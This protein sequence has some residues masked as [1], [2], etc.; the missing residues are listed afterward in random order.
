M[1]TRRLMVALVASAVGLAVAPGTALAQA[2]HLEQA[3]AETKEAI[4]EGKRDEPAS[5]VEHAVNAIDHAHAAQKANPS[6]HIKSGISHLKKAVKW[7]KH[8]H[9]SRRVAKATKEA[10]TALTHLEAAK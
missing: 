10:E 5:L 9:S 8:T 1:L 2:S 6:D 7:A 3:I 4:H